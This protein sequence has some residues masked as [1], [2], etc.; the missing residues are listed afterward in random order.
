MNTLKITRQCESYFPA[1][2]WL[3]CVIKTCMVGMIMNTNACNFETKQKQIR[4]LTTCC[5]THIITCMSNP[6]INL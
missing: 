2:L 6:V 3:V 1:S 5:T 4:K